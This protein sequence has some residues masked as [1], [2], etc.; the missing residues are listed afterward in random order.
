[1]KTIKVR[2]STTHRDLDNDKFTVGCLEDMAEQINTGILPYTVEH[3]PRNPPIGRMI[4]AQVNLLDD[5]E[6]G[7]DG[8]V[9]LFDGDFSTLT[10]TGEREIP[11]R[12]YESG[13]LKLVIDRG[14][15]DEKNK[16]DLEELVQILQD[17]NIEEEMKKSVDPIQVLIIGS[18]FILTSIATGF[19]GQIGA[20]KYLALK[21]KLSKIYEETPN[22][23]VEKILIFAATITHENKSINVEVQFTNPTPDD[24]DKFFDE[25]IKELDQILPQHFKQDYGFARIVFEYKSGNL[26]IKFAVLKNGVPLFPNEPVS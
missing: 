20:D 26:K 10:N 11:I 19:L 8:T 16:R 12:K 24:I 7:L 1:M 15:K 18:G 2:I 17:V 14:F 6:Y 25:G 5:G 9:E 23:R 13:I 4:E 3:D 21:K 22:V